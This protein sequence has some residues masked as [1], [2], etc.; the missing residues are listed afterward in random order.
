MQVR[1]ILDKEEVVRAKAAGYVAGCH[2]V[3]GTPDCL[4][5]VLQEPES[6]EIMQHTKVRHPSTACRCNHSRRTRPRTTLLAR[7]PPSL[8]GLRFWVATPRHATET[9]FFFDAA[10]CGEVLNCVAWR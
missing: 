8:L 3:V 5:E 1:G 9:F 2:V 7:F 10:A 4:A 6:L